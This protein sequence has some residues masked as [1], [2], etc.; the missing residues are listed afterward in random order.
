[1]HRHFNYIIS[2]ACAYRVRA[3]LVKKTV[4][5]KLKFNHAFALAELL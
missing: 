2:I 3:M 4:K 1:M 5:W